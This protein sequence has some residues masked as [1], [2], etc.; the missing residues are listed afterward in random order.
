MQVKKNLGFPHGRGSE[1]KGWKKLKGGK[2]IGGQHS[3]GHGWGKRG[4]KT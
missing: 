1:E 4:T 2:E 3:H